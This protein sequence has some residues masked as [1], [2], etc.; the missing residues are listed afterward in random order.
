[1]ALPRCDT[2]PHAVKT[3][4]RR[5]RRAIQAE[6]SAAQAQLELLEQF[7][8]QLRNS[9]DSMHCDLSVDS[10]PKGKL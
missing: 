9:P 8:Q 3:P 2:W 5:K 6:I 7:E 10:A 4:I 1:M